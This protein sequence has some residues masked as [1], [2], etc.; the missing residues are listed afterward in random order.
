MKK[1]GEEAFINSQQLASKKKGDV[2]ATR[3]NLA[4]SHNKTSH[5]DQNFTL[6]GEHPRPSSGT[7][8]K[9]SLP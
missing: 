8:P 6:F 3:N 9:F 7:P 4:W 2:S 1:Y 5:V